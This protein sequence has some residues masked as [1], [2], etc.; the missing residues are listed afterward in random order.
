MKNVVAVV[1]G[2]GRG[3][4]LL[5]LTALRSKPAVPLAGKY[6]LIDIPI[7]NCLNSSINQIYVLT[8]FQSVS[9]HRHIRGTYRFDNFSGGFVEILAAQQTM[10]SDEQ[11]DWYQ[12]TA[13]AVR[14]NLRY[15]AQVE[16]DYVLILSGDQLYRMDFRDMIT[17][18]EAAKAD[19]TIAAKP[20][21]RGEAGAMGIM[22]VNNTGRVVGFLE[23][24]QTDEELNDVAM[25]PQW[26]EAHG[27]ES[28]GRDCLASMGI[29]LFQRDT[30]LAALEKTNYRDFGKEVFPAS[31]RS[32]NVQVHM[33]DGYWE[34]IGTIRAFYD[35]N[36]RLAHPHPPFDL[37]SATAPIFTR[38][39]FLPPTRAD[40]AT[41]QQSL[42]SDGCVIGRETRIENSVIGLRCRI[43]NNVTI[44]N[45]VIMGADYYETPAQLSADR[46]AGRPPIGIGDGAVIEGAIVDKNCHVGAGAQVI[47]NPQQQDRVV[48]ENF[49]ML[50]GIVVLPKNAV[51]PD[52]WRRSAP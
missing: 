42:V 9:L 51:L 3:T 50:D 45:S 28:R 18:H 16:T 10:D 31:M 19:V 36:L 20:V 24:P 21:S 29:Y 52:D 15:F 23:K 6:R 38:A 30:L 26:L 46:S 48:G 12:G 27:I 8:Q 11:R 2:G 4:R 47:G 37:A 13:D 43:G 22:R 40:G 34:D 35:A 1:L 14:K 39:R 32:R 5:P 49:E 44:R 17:T 7:S 41:I 33:F 25:D